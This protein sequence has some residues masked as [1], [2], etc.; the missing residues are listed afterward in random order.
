MILAQSY[1]NTK[2]ST[3]LPACSFSV[4]LPPVRLMMKNNLAVALASD[5]NPGSSPNFMKYELCCESCCIKMKMT[6]EEAYAAINQWCCYG[7]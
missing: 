7:S 4:S 1:S 3:T 6:P 5:F 2:G